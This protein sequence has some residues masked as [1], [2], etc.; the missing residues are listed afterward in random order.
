MFPVR[1]YVR[2]VLRLVEFFPGTVRPSFCKQTADH[3]VATQDTLF[4]DIKVSVIRNMDIF[5][6]L[7]SALSVKYV[8]VIVHPLRVLCI[9][10]STS[11]C[12]INYLRYRLRCNV[13]NYVDTMTLH[14]R[15]YTLLC[16]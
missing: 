7:L 15:V 1:L 12:Y 11:P 3:H 4:V 13:R 6:H 5:Q 14:G 2:L 8:T 9:H 10:Y 16:S